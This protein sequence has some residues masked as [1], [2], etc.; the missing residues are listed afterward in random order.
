MIDTNGYDYLVDSEDIWIRTVMACQS[1]KVCFLM[2]Q[3]QIDQIRAMFKTPKESKARNMLA[4]PYEL[5][6]TSAFLFGFSKIGLAEFGPPARI[7]EIRGDASED[8]LDALLAETARRNSAVLVTAD[9]RL[10]RKSERVGLV[11][12]HPREL[13]DLICSLDRRQ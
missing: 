7:D 1:D 11:V 2:T 4:I 13:V 9:K 6:T 3:V 8:D 10:R 12:W 5:V